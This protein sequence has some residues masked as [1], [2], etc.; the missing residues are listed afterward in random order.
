M[1]LSAASTFF[2]RK[3]NSANLIFAFIAFAGTIRI[4]ERFQQSDAVIDVAL[5]VIKFSQCEL[6]GKNI[7]ACIDARDKLFP[8][9]GELP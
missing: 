9:Y 8:R 5:I 1:T 6:I 2:C 7:A 4:A 3:S